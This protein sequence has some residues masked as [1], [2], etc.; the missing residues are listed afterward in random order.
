MVS[1]D[2]DD[3]DVFRSYLETV[4]TQRDMNAF[5]DTDIPVT[6]EDKIITLSTC[7]KGMANR[8]YLVQAV[9]VSIDE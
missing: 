7:Y 5:I 4:L 9:L 1:F 2:F 3:P 6:E 8:R